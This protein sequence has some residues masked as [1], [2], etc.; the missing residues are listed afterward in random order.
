MRGRANWAAQ[1]IRKQAKTSITLRRSSNLNNPCAL[2]A[3]AAQGAQII[4]LKSSAAS[5]LTG[6]VVK[7][8]RLTL[9]GSGGDATIYLVLADADTSPSGSLTL[10][11]SPPLHVAHALGDA[12]TFTLNYTDVVYQCLVR[13]IEDFDI[14]AVSNGHQIRILPRDA[15]KPTPQVG[16]RLNGAAIFRVDPISADDGMAA[17]MCHIETGA[18]G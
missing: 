12:V 17:Y 8:S 16:D 2:A 3:A 11:I 6:Q 9:A 18:P 1:V 7:G 15:N 14:Q 13:A 10:S 5:R 4:I